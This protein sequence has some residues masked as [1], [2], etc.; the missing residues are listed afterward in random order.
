MTKIIFLD[1]DGPLI[2]GRMYYDRITS[3][4]DEVAGQFK[5]DPIAVGMIRKLCQESGAHVVFNTAHNEHSHDVMRSKARYNGFDDLLHPKVPRTCFRVVFDRR[6]DAV[7]DWIAK[8]GPVDEWVAIDDELFHDTNQVY[9]D[10]NLGITINN[11]FKALQIL[12]CD[13]GSGLII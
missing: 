13:K 3:T 12:G 11:F 4:Y 5:Y 2:P 7:N 1:V 6:I 9:I 8:N 10:F